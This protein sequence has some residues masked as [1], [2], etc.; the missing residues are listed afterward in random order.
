MAVTTSEHDLEALVDRVGSCQRRPQPLA[1]SRIPPRPPRR[2]FGTPEPATGSLVPGFG[3][4]KALPPE[5]HCLLQ[6]ILFD[7][8]QVRDA[9][10]DH[11]GL[12]F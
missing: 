6:T 1:S 7:P 2:G 5:L 3:H 12:A 9:L 10:V 11:G 4:Q 8:S